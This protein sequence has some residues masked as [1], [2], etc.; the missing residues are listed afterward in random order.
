MNV[1]NA[2]MEVVV[3]YLKAYD[4]LFSRTLLALELCKLSPAIISSK[5][6]ML[7]LLRSLVEARIVRGRPGFI[8][9]TLRRPRVMMKQSTLS[10]M[11]QGK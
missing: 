3:A 4:F 2:K 7:N 10:K 8:A 9:D 11:E 6:E 1:K 5:D